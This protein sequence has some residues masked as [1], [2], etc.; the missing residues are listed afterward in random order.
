[1]TALPSTVRAPADAHQVL[2]RCRG[3][4]RAALTEAF[5]RMHP[6][7][8]AMVTRTQEEVAPAAEVAR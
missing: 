7:V 2:A 4:V 1:M 5:G 8:D 3:S 6:W